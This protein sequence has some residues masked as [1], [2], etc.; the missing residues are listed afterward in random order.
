MLY[1]GLV[2]EKAKQI[3][4]ISSDKAVIKLAKEIEKSC[5]DTKQPYSRLAIEEVIEDYFKVQLCEIIKQPRM[6]GNSRIIIPIY[7]YF[8]HTYVTRNSKELLTIFNKKSIESISQYLR[9]V[10]DFIDSKDK[11]F[12]NHLKTLINHLNETI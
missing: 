11:Q 3:Q 6:T 7:C 8:I 2:I 9:I 1:S 10:N 4:T 12:N 5:E